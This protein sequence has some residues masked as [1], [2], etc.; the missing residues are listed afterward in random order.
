MVLL[1]DD[2]WFPTHDHANEDGILAIGGDLSVERL[3]LAYENG[4]FPWY[5]DDE[6]I[7]WWSPPERMV[8]KVQEYKVPRSV[9]RSLKNTQFEISINQAFEAVIHHCRYTDRKDGLGTWINDDIVT[10]YT[11]LHQMGKANSIEVWQDDKLVGGMYGVDVG[12]VFCGESMFSLVP[13][14][15]KAAFVFMAQYLKDLGYQLLD[16]QVYNEHLDLL[17][18]KEIS[19]DEFLTILSEHQ[20]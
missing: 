19:R 12:N 10:A 8:V 18:A 15:S 1:D 4:I 9:R 6:P 11:Q 16:C 7:L 14:A 13:S 2:I 5:S 20:D 17:G 3:L